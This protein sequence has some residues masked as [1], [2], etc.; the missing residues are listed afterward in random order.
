MYCPLFVL[1]IFIRLAETYDDDD[2]KY[3]VVSLG[4]GGTVTL[5]S[6]LV[7]EYFKGLLLNTY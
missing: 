7:P 5:T 3:N 6:M 1:T 2:D 4:H